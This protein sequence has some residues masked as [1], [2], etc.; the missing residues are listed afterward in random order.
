ML[1]LHCTIFSTRWCCN[2]A[3]LYCGG[4]WRK[5]TSGLGDAG[6]KDATLPHTKKTW[7]TGHSRALIFWFLMANFGKAGDCSL[8]VTP[9]CAVLASGFCSH[10][11]E[12]LVPPSPSE[13]IGAHTHPPP[14]M[15]LRVGEVSRHVG[16]WRRVRCSGYWLSVQNPSEVQSRLCCAT[17][18]CASCH[19]EGCRGCRVVQLEKLHQGCSLTAWQLAEELPSVQNSFREIVINSM[20]L[21]DFTLT[22]QKCQGHEKQRK[23]EEMLQTGGE[24]RHG[25]CACT[26]G[27]EP[28]KGAQWDDW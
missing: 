15:L 6:G 3:H 21:N 20:G 19:P 18:P 4:P 10:N 27:P 26:V 25:S 1:W 24:G 28:E 17:F 7:K 16:A 5:V 12:L 13:W 2:T 8:Q 14:Q 11:G 22:L 9:G 23:A